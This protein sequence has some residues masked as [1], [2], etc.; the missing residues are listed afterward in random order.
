MARSLRE[1][2]MRMR[3]MGIKRMLGALVASGHQVQQQDVGGY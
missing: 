3:R 2:R 1:G